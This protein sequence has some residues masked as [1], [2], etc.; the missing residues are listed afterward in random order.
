MKGSA[1]Q[2][3]KAAVPSAPVSLAQSLNNRL[4]KEEVNASTEN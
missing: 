4:D 2:S 1:L 3:V